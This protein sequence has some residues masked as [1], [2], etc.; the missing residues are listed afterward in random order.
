MPASVEY[1]FSLPTPMVIQQ[2]VNKPFLIQKNKANFCWL[3]WSS[4]QLSSAEGSAHSE[5][6]GWL[7]FVVL[8]G[9]RKQGPFGNTTKMTEAFFLAIFHIVGGGVC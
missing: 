4:H 1:H 2:E 8:D 5:H 6:S 3:G 7:K 9:Y